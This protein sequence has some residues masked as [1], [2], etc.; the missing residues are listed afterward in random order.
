MGSREAQPEERQWQWLEEG[1][2]TAC[3]CVCYGNVPLYQ[4]LW[5]CIFNMNSP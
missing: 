5:A 2:M 1:H 3:H 4:G